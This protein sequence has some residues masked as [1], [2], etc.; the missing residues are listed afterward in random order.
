MSLLTTSRDPKKSFILGTAIEITSVFSV[1]TPTSAKI[2][3]LDPALTK[4]VD[5]ANMTQQAN[6]VYRY[7]YQSVSTDTDG[8]Y[9]A[10][11]AVVSGGYTVISERTFELFRQS[12][13]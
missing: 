2:T 13:T 10:R 1:D 5:L 7:I 9:I 11:I 4:V 12:G 3:I 6:K 8:I